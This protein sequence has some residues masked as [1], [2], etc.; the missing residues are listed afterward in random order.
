MIFLLLFLFHST[1][2]YRKWSAESFEINKHAHN[3]S[4]TSSPKHF[5]FQ[6]YIYFRSAVIRHKLSKLNSS[7]KND[8]NY[9]HTIA[10][11]FRSLNDPFSLAAA[12]V[13]ARI[14]DCS[15]CCMSFSRRLNL[16]PE[17][18][19]SALTL[20]VCACQTPYFAH[21]QPSVGVQKSL[22]YKLTRNYHQTCLTEKVYIKWVC[23]VNKIAE[24]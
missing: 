22:T 6:A 12:S 10:I 3:L 18:V 20:A 8:C 17:H 21:F 9:Q 13:F 5:H 15:E 16:N 2:R 19:S 23:C 7:L 1:A 14:S 24:I 11:A 4:L